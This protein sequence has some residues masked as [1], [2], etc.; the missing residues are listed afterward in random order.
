MAENLTAA[1]DGFDPALLNPPWAFHEQ[2]RLNSPVL[3]APGMGFYLVTKYEDVNAALK[4][5]TTCSSRFPGMF[6]TGLSFAPPSPA[7]EAAHAKGYRW[8]PTL[9]FSDAPDHRRHRNVLQQAFS[10]R[11]VRQLESMVQ[12]LCDEII[13][14]LDI[15]GAVD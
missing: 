9:F 10:P 1:A 15:G 6:G 14:G 8:E 7:K 2:L 3:E 11:R 13:D 4:D 12:A 5:D